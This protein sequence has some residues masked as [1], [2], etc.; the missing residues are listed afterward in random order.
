MILE[1]GAVDPQDAILLGAR[2]LDPPE[3]EYI[4]SIGLRTDVD[5]LDAALE[6][7]T[8]STSRSTSTRSSRSEIQPFMPEPGGLTLDEVEQLLSRVCR[9]DDDPRRRLQRLRGRARQ[10][11]AADPA[12]AAPWGC[13]SRP[14]AGS[15]LA[16]SCPNGSTSP[17]STGTRRPTTVGS[18]IRTPARAAARTTATTS[19]RRR[20]DV[21]TQCGH[22]FPVHARDADRAADRRGQLR[23]GGGRAALRRPARVLRPAAVHRAAGGGRALDRP[24]RGDGDRPRGDRGR[25]PASSR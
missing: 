25:S 8:A 16:R 23:R 9:A 13:N 17:S 20:S 11:R 5:E 3:R 18:R 15:K 22:H 24:R 10:R 4:A 1:S 7:T 21:C 14:G 19:S 12:A 2:S 6:G